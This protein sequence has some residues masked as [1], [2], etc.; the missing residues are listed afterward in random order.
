[1]RVQKKWAIPIA[2]IALL[3]VARL[4]LPYFVT[5]Y[6]N[7]VLSEIEGYQGSIE[8][9]DI[10][11][12][13]GAYAINNL[14][15]EKM[16]GDIPVPFLDI[17]K[18]D[19]S[20]EWEA[21]FDGAV[22]GEIQ[23]LY[24]RLNFV[25][26][27][28]EEETQ[29]GAE[30]DWTEPLKDLMPLQINRFEIVRGKISYLDFHAEPKVDIAIDSLNAV[31]LNLNN[32]T[33][34]PE[35]L[36]SKVKL[37]GTSVGGGL[38]VVDA[39]MN[40]LKEIPDFDINL[41]FTEVNLPALNDFIKAYGKFDVERGTFNLYSEIILNNGTFDGYVKPVMIDMKVLDLSKDSED[42][43]NVFQLVWEG[44]VELGSEI[45][46]NHKEDQVASRVP[47]Q[48]EIGQ[49]ETDVWTTIFTVLRNA[50]IEALKREVD[51]TVKLEE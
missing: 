36:P 50:Y 17:E 32:A 41:E 21:I 13:R 14:K 7:K 44:I 22:V 42:K 28:S 12:Y 34:N 4:L 37:T 23:L 24:P 6:V 2:I 5:N 47:L 35:K 9:V 3:I 8:G 27:P 1:M 51:N 31:A 30:T 40:I 39:E 16:D 25:A 26:G 11:L 48:G 10:S 43:R 29:T 33:D 20:V 38:L 18:I 49:V 46:E 15:L 45:F 19:L